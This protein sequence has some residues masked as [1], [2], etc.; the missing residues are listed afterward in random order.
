MLFRKCL[1]CESPA[2][3]YDIRL[4]RRKLDNVYVLNCKFQCVNCSQSR[5]EDIE[6]ESKELA[7]NTKSFIMS[8]GFADGDNNPV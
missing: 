8:F 3:P 2:L 6:F 7:Q 1:H 4:E 5:S